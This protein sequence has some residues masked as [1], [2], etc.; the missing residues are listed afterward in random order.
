M[1]TEMRGYKRRTPGR[2]NAPVQSKSSSATHS[3]S[4]RQELVAPKPHAAPPQEKSDDAAIAAVAFD[5]R[6][7]RRWGLRGWVLWGWKERRRV[8]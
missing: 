8:K 5:H 1:L 6:N 4:A 7:V 2:L 3:E